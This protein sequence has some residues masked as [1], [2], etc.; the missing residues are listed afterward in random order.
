MHT[1]L[2]RYLG[3][4]TRTGFLSAPPDDPNMS[5]GPGGSDSNNNANQQQQQKSGDD[6]D[7][8]DIDA[9]LNAESEEELDLG[10]DEGGGDEE[11]TQEQKEAGAALGNEIKQLI[12]KMNFDE[13]QIPD[14]FDW[15]DKKQIA[16]LMA[17]NQQ[18][19][20]QGALSLVPK[21]L[22]HALGILVPRLE[23]RIDSAVGGQSRKS[24]A[25][26]AFNDLGYQGADKAFAKSIYERAI[27]ESKM[28][29]EKA[30][31]ATSKAMEA[32]GKTSKG[33]AGNGNSRGRSGKQPESRLEG[34]D[35]LR[36]IFGE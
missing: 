26:Q 17:K 23:K 25:T 32:L 31:R 35:A 12:G 28:T 36:S 34:D 33:P 20:A 9:L 22:N 15:N 4:I 13:S 27:R 18:A 11:L 7:D 21:I 2:N 10:D 14:D 6:D 24:S 16:G 5:G 30:A 19:A 8:I 1:L 29:P 3:K